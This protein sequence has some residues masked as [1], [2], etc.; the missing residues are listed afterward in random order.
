MPPVWGAEMR[1]RPRSLAMLPVASLLAALAGVL[2]LPATPASASA[3]LTTCAEA[4]FRSAVLAGGTVTFNVNCSSV[5]L[6][7]PITIASG[8]NVT[9]VGTGFSVTLDGLGKS[10]HFIV[11]GGHLTLRAI[12]LFAGAVTGGSGGFG[13]SGSKGDVG[14]FGGQGGNGTEGQ[15]GSTGSSDPGGNGTAGGPGTAGTPA[16]N[17]GA[18][19]DAAGGSLLISSGQVDLTNVVLSGNRVTGGSGGPG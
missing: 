8:L 3:T 14:S 18:G 13:A 19:S 10:R 9:I 15:C 5:P 1:R 17:G 2:A 16:A 12:T 4:P 6:H 11:Q 7:S